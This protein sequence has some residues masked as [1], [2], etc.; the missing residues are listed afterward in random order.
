V[1][2]FLLVHKSKPK[3]E[4]KENGARTSCD[5]IPLLLMASLDSIFMQVKLICLWEQWHCF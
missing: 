3:K 1:S 5:F 2:I 4:M